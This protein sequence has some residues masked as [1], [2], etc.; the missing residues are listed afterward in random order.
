MITATM[1]TEPA[2]GPLEDYRCTR[3]GT[4]AI[5]LRITRKQFGLGQDPRWHQESFCESCLEIAL[6]ELLDQEYWDEDVE[7]KLERG[8]RVD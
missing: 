5:G 6:D 2:E 7:A 8:E 3:C 1:L 4:R